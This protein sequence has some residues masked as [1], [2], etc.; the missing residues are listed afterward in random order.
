LRGFC[1]HWLVL[2][3][4]DSFSLFPFN[5]AA[6]AKHEAVQINGEGIIKVN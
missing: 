1:F 2:A 6:A 4:K 5:V 3:S